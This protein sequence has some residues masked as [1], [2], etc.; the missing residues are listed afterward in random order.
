MKT[1]KFSALLLLIAISSYAQKKESVFL[2]PGKVPGEIKEKAEGISAFTEKDGVL[3]FTEV[4]NPLMEV[5]LPESSAKKAGVI[6]CP[7]GGYRHLAYN[8]EGTEIAEW[9]NKN[10]YA[11]FVLQYRVPQKMEGAL[12]DAQRAIRLIRQNA[13]KWNVDPE[14]IGMIGFSA[15]GSLS[16]RA[17][18]LYNKE[19]YTPVDAADK[20]TAKPAFAL[21]IYPGMLDNGPGKNLSPEL[22]LTKDTPPLFMF[23]A[24][25]DFVGNSSIVMA[26][27]LRKAAI[28]F[29]LHIVPAGGHGYGLRPGNPAAEAWPYLALKWMEKV[30][31]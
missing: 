27:A 22:E 3:R 10:G 20:L 29:E 28:P 8:K 6:V 4:T 17:A 21:L 25:D 15:G 26:L 19:T 24:C 1:F 11:A 12:Q 23:Q 31:N 7:G 14:M 13:K 16:A 30:R 2:W 5:W 9:L 18:T